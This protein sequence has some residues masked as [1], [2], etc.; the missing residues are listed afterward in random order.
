MKITNYKLLIT[1]LLLAIL[2]LAVPLFAA[3]EDDVTDVAEQKSYVKG[4]YVEGADGDTLNVKKGEGFDFKVP[5]IMI[6]GQI[7]T[8]VLLKRETTSLEDMQGVKNVLY[9]KERVSMPYAY[10]GEDALSP[11]NAGKAGARDFTGKLKLSAGT[12][13]NITADGT[14]GKS[15]DEINSAVLRLKHNNYENRINDRLVTGNTNS[16]ECFYTTSYGDFEAIYGLKGE[17][18]VYDNP[19]TSNMFY[20]NYSLQNYEAGVSVSGNI[21]TFGLD[22]AVSYTYFDE[23]NNYPDLL[24]KEN[25][26]AIKTNVEKDFTI[27]QEKK[28]KTML[29]LDAWGG[30]AAIEEQRYGTFNM[31]LIL[32]GIFY[33][34]PVVVKGGLRIQDYNLHKNFY[35]MSP[36]LSASYDALPYL[37]FYADFKPKMQVVD[38]TEFLKLP[39]TRASEF[40]MPLES[41]NFK[42]G[43]QANFFDTF[44]DLFFGYKSV[45]DNIYLDTAEG[46]GRHDYAYA[47]RNNDIDYTYAGISVETLK[48]KN[49]KVKFDYEYFNIIKQTTATTYMPHNVLE[50]KVIYQ[51][52]EWEFTV[53]AS[54][55]SSRLGA[56]GH[57]APSYADID[58]TAARKITENFTLSG[59]VNNILNNPD[60]LLY[61]YEDKGINLG[62][63][64]VV[65]F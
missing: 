24:F 39:F 40:D 50:T 11:Q 45:S 64:A 43:A 55:K 57:K 41:V 9:E 30:E 54:L 3:D 25:R 15:F 33:F 19:Y 23:K 1:N 4:Q 51:P 46:A 32:M 7:D 38:N 29:S 59:Y 47:Y 8:K 22:A 16:G 27:A 14:I 36:Y 26:L 60:Y 63:T 44:I 62:L 56:T 42:A 18:N 52:A 5:E 34:E 28:I 61:Y 10:L 20:S 58:F 31:D 21:N 65:K 17:F 12:Y 2:F 53:A 37:S 6:T 49:I 13:I 35:R 48:L